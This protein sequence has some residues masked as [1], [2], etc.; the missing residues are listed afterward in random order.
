MKTSLLSL[1]AAFVLFSSTAS[2]AAAP[3]HRDDD[4]RRTENSRYDDRND[5]DF[6]YGYDKKHRVTP[7]EKA[8]WEAAHRTDRR[9]Y[10]KRD[11]NNRQADRYDRRDSN[12]RYDGRNEKDFNYGYDKKHKVTSQERARWEAAHRNDR[13]R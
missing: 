8:R 9:D 3:D 2:L 1:A 4:R 11:Y 5:R 13:N 12:N 7:A 10:D 6:N